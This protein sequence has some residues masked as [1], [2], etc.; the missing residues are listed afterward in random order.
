MTRRIS[1][2]AFLFAVAVLLN[3]AL[4]DA[5]ARGGEIKHVVLVMVDGVAASYLDDP[6]AALPTL[7]EMRRTGAS[8]GG[9]ITT[10]PS[11]TWPSHTS[12]ITGT[13]P[14]LHGVLANT[15]YDR[16]TRRPVVYIGDP[17]LTKDQAIHVPTLYDAAHAAGLKTA[18]VLSAGPNGG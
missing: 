16:R 8:A 14:R 10:F 13:R 12:L 4:L 5:V 2:T 15:V 3:A 11:V 6:K 1:G 9:M 7:R 18:G 17:Q